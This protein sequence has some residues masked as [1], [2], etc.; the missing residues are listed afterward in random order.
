MLHVAAAAAATRLRCLTL[1]VVC[2]LDFSSL[3]FHFSTGSQSELQ[4]SISISVTLVNGTD[5]SVA[6]SL[7]PGCCCGLPH[8][9]VMH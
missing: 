5:A 4:S 2:W 3:P 6:K 9:F 1:E 7:C 8:L